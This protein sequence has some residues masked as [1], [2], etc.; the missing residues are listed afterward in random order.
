MTSHRARD[1]SDRLRL[2]E[3]EP[4]SRANE[5]TQDRRS[6]IVLGVCHEEVGAVVRLQDRADRV[7]TDQSNEGLDHVGVVTAPSC[8]QHD[9]ERPHRRFSSSVRPSRGEGVIGICSRD[10]PAEEVDRGRI[11]KCRQLGIALAIEPSMVLERHHRR[12]LLAGLRG[13]QDRSCPFLGMELDLGPPLRVESA[14]ILQRLRRDA[15]LSDVMQEPAYGHHSQC[16]VIHADQPTEG[17]AEDAHV[18]RVIERVLVVT[19]H[20][21]EENR[22]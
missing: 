14:W 20:A 6:R 8:L 10:Q 5:Q 12:D 19:L 2:T 11:P 1:Q 18:H 9:F 7:Q 13:C 3:S 22:G 15:H 21:G 17:D 16:L 4:V